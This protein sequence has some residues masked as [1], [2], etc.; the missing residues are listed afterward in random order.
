MRAIAL[1]ALV[2]GAGVV[3]IVLTGDHQDA[4]VAWA[5]FGPTVG[6]S[7]VGTGLYAWRTRPQS[8]IGFLMVL[9]GFAWF[10]STV[11]FADP[12]LVYTAGLVLAGLWG[13]VFLHLGVSFPSGR[14]GSRLD[15]A[16]VIAGYVIF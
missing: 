4:K 7:F 14:L 15:R 11:E 12:P 2:A 9:L 8:R 3:A 13:G 6:W 5:I 16:I 1:A 10:L